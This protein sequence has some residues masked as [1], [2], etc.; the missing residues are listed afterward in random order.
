MDPI[1][2]VIAREQGRLK[3]FIRSRVP[4]ESDADDV[5]QDVFFEL[6]QAYEA[7]TPLR[8]SGAWLYRVAKNRITDLF[9]RRSAENRRLV[10]PEPADGEDSLS[11]DS[12]L[13][14]PEGGP[15]AAY[16]RRILLEE[17]DVA[18]EELPD[19][20]RQVFIAHEIEGVSFKE[21]AEATGISLNTLLSR[22]HY[23]VRHLRKRLQEIYKEFS[24]V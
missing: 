13:P 16:A 12:W 9:R 23:A 11:L 1:D 14:S 24:D 7:L 8:E 3:R 17:L 10:L 2:D 21:M 20:Q 5:L 6:V 15:D 19:E 18:L 22:K 4:T